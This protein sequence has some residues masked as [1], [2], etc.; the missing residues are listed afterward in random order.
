MDHQYAVSLTACISALVLHL[1]ASQV[2]VLKN[3]EYG[4]KQQ[5]GEDTY[6]QV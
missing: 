2:F 3:L 4:G 1:G 6:F 5:V